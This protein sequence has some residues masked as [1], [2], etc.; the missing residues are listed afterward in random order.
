MTLNIRLATV[1]DADAIGDIHVTSW[2]MT[3]RGIV[4]QAYLDA[5]D[6]KARQA[7]WRQR[8]E[9]GSILHVAENAAGIVGFAAGGPYRGEHLRLRGELYVMYVRALFHRCGI[10]ASLFATVAASL[11]QPFGLWVIA[12]NPA[13]RFYE[14]MGGR[15]IGKKTEDIG[16]AKI[17]EYLY[18][19]E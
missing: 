17:E 8:L 11:T 19:Y 7:T 13:C 2:Q 1:E 5:M 4:P 6:I 15:L 18:L 9:E 3:Y 10:G 16:G 14:A 12:A